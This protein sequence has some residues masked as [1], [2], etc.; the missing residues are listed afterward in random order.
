MV[1]T[2]SCLAT[3]ILAAYLDSDAAKDRGVTGVYLLSGYLKSDAPSP[4]AKLNGKHDDAMDLDAT[5][6]TQSS[7]NGL[8]DAQ[9]EPEVVKIKT[10]LL[11]QQDE[12]EGGGALSSVVEALPLAATFLRQ[13]LHPANSVVDTARTAKSALFSPAPASH[14]YA[15]APARLTSLDLLTAS[16]LSLIRP[17][18]R[19]QKWKAAPESTPAYG[20]IVHPEGERKIAQGKRKAPPMPPAAAAAPK[21]G[22]SGLSS[23]AKK[24]DSEDVKPSPAA[25]AKGK[26]KEKETASG[27]GTA[28]AKKEE[29]KIRPIGQLGG[30]FARKFDDSTSKKSKGKKKADSDE[31]DSDEE[32]D[33]KPK[34]VVPAKRKST[35]PAVSRKKPA[36]AAAA[37]P[38]PAKAAPAKKDAD[39]IMDDD[40]DWDMDEEAFLEVERA[41]EA[42]AKARADKA[43][44]S[45]AAASAA[46]TTTAAKSNESKAERQKREL[47]V[48][49]LRS[50]AR[51]CTGCSLRGPPDELQAMMKSD[52]MDVDEDKKPSRAQS[53]MSLPPLPLSFCLADRPN[54]AAWA[55]DTVS[56]TSSSS[57]TAQSKAANDKKKASAAPAQKSL[58]SFF[59][60]G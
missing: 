36:A 19:E 40:D 59:K 15:L 47:E 3:R 6:T 53:R 21:A 5:A 27:K 54:R 11:V 43:N 42:S 55:R 18:V 60:K 48:S 45:K 37:A 38:P 58:G 12:L 1:R 29:P 30:L 25:K 7:Q 31:D 51:L 24:D 23:K 50:L 39:I 41:A 26:G 57:S 16:S 46:S 9:D 14:I 44:A 28:K 56:R 17:E 33:V 10:M 20:G 34:K 13:H 32:E 35:S 49:T 52:D 2:D 4:A 22:P 8:D